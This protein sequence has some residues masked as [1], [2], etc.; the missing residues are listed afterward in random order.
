MSCKIDFNLDWDINTGRIRQNNFKVT[1]Y[2]NDIQRLNIK[3]KLGDCD[4]SGDVLDIYF[5]SPIEH[6]PPIVQIE[7]IGTDNTVQTT[8]QGNPLQDFGEWKIELVLKRA[9][10]SSY[11]STSKASYLVV[12][13]SRGRNIPPIASKQTQA[14][15]DGLSDKLEKNIAKGETLSTELKQNTVDGTTANTELIATTQKAETVKT[16]L[17]NLVNGIPPLQ[18]E[19]DDLKAG[20]GDLSTLTTTEKTNLVGATN[21]IKGLTETNKQAIDTERTAR[22]TKN[23]ELQGEINTNKQGIANSARVEDL[24]KE[25]IRAKAEE[26]KIA[27]RLNAMGIKIINKDGVDVAIF[28][29]QPTALG[30]SGQIIEATQNYHY[31]PLAQTKALI[32]KAIE[33]KPYKAP[34]AIVSGANSSDTVT[35]DQ[36]LLT[37]LRGFEIETTV[38]GGTPSDPAI[39][40]STFMPFDSHYKDTTTDYS[41]DII[42]NRSTRVITLTMSGASV[43]ASK[44]SVTVKLIYN[45][46]L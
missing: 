7:T 10:G 4:L 16:D 42:F 22:A 12:E 5:I 40:R 8:I 46:V 32:D 20:Q 14:T 18:K 25:I 39:S 15:V 43:T 9:D 23:M 33:A 19:L 17:D 26:S 6:M 35:I 34:F 44:V 29:K 37:D 31:P 1:R 24:D 45:N 3:L 41:V 13:N 11:G 21:E 27:N 38:A 30:I 2:S 36:S 28:E